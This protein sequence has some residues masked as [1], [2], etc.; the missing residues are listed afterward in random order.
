M[1]N[2]LNAP[3]D[4]MKEYLTG[5]MS[6]TYA[7]NLGKL[8]EADTKGKTLLTKRRL[9]DPNTSYLWLRQKQVLVVV[10]VPKMVGVKVSADLLLLVLRLLFVVARRCSD[11]LRDH[12]FPP[13]LRC[14]LSYLSSAQ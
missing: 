11:D 8:N 10:D 13:T 3:W 5:I 9:F 4:L 1:E 14:E 7:L 2:M 12:E 6:L